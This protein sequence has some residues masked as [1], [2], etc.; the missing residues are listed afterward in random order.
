[1]AG[2]AVPMPQ[3]VVAEF[4]ARIQSSVDALMPMTT[5]RRLDDGRRVEY[6]FT[7]CTLT[8]PDE[9]LYTPTDGGA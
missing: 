7:G 8:W 2:D 3:D 6:H 5:Y 4:R 9:M 1:M